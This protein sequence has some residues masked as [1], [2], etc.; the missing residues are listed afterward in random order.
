L[1]KHNG[2]TDVVSAMLETIGVGTFPNSGVTEFDAVEYGPV[3]ILLT[4][5]TLNTYAVPLTRPV[6]VTDVAVETVS[7]KVVQVLPLS[8]EY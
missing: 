1:S 8:L 2:I 5:A 6:T 4:A 3:P 7:V